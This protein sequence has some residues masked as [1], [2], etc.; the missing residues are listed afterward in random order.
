MAKIELSELI[1]TQEAL[2]KPEI[3]P[4][5]IRFIEAGGF[6]HSTKRRERI[7]LSLCTAKGRKIYIHNGHH[8]LLALYLSGHR[9]LQESER[10]LI[11]WNYDKYMEFSPETGFVAIFDH[12]PKS[13]PKIGCD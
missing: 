4:E 9:E 13:E 6:F 8:R 10:I 12:E 7:Q 5:L 1:H 11:D 2:R 3:I